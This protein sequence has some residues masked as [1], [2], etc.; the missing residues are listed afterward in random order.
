[1]KAVLIALAVLVGFDAAVWG[2]AYRQEIVREFLIAAHE[3]GA[4]SW[5]WA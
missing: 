3:V 2:G 1:M 4:L 5:A